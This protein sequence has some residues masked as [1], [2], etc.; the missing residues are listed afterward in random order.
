M[1]KIAISVACEQAD[2]LPDSVPPCSSVVI[3]ANFLLFNTVDHLWPANSDRQ[4]A[5]VP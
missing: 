2:I 1:E 5:E 4:H 3:L